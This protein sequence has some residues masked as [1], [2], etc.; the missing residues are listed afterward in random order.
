MLCRLDIPTGQQHWIGLTGTSRQYE[1]GEEGET[2]ANHPV[3]FDTREMSRY[4][5]CREMCENQDRVILYS[6]FMFYY[7][8]QQSSSY[9]NDALVCDYR[10]IIG[11]MKLSA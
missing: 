5:K 3:M 9:S 10:K 4:A 11:L 1:S 8:L 7:M 6:S 2:R